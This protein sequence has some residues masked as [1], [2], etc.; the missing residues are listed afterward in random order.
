MFNKLLRLFVEMAWQKELVPY[1][2]YDPKILK[3]YKVIKRSFHTA[4]KRVGIE[5]FRFHDCRHT[6]A[7]QLVMAVVDLTTIKEL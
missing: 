5:D 4:L 6:F 7:S 2:F 3:R 1:G